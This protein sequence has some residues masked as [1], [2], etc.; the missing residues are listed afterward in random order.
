MLSPQIL[1]E[2]RV[3]NPFPSHSGLMRL[4]P[5]FA[6]LGIQ[7]HLFVEEGGIGFFVEVLVSE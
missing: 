7:T 5:D 1:E 6:V 4:V 3:L 2:Q